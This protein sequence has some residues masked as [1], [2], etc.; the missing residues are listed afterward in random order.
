MGSAELSAGGARVLGEWAELGLDLGQPP[1]A[2]PLDPVAHAAADGVL[3]RDE[4]HGQ[5]LV[6]GAGPGVIRHHDDAAQR[7][8]LK[9]SVA[10]Q[11][12]SPGRERELESR[13]IVPKLPRSD[14]FQACIVAMT[15]SIPNRGLHALCVSFC[16][17]RVIFCLIRAP[18][19]MLVLGISLFK[20][21]SV[22]LFCFYLLPGKELKLY[23]L[24]VY[25]M[26]PLL[27]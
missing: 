11:P 7:E 1:R 21:I 26:K 2:R 9:G 10:L 15:S 4:G 13:G 27:K 17:V 3:G 5:A 18:N 16:S 19:E 6:R 20:S 25:S 12:V 14:I 22:H 8:Q 23:L 24:N